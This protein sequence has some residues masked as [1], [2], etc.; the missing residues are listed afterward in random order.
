MPTGDNVIVLSG[1]T[2]IVP[3]VLAIPQPPV[4]VIVYVNKPDVNGIPLI[5]T[6]SF[7]QAPETPAGR[8]LIVAPVAH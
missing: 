2:V 4:N 3:V 6:V 8:P 7:A 5:V 1:E